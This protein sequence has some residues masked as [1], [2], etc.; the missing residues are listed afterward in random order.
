MNFNFVQCDSIPPRGNNNDNNVSQYAKAVTDFVNSGVKIAKYV[1][2][3]NKECH[4]MATAINAFI[5]GSN[6]PYTW[7]VVRACS[8]GKECYLERKD[9]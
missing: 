1:C 3:S 6:C 4:K 5:K 2:D 7:N 9:M 8:R